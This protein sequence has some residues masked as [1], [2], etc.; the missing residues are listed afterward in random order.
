M[1]CFTFS[2]WIEICDEENRPVEHETTTSNQKKE[3][4][5]Y[6]THILNSH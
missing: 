5:Q 1:S 3:A 6:I 4:N 2:D